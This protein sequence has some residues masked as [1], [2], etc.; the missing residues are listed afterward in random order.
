VP[1]AP[2]VVKAV[3]RPGATPPAGTEMPLMLDR[4]WQSEW[5]ATPPLQW[6]LTADDR[7][8]LE[9]F[10][11]NLHRGLATWHD[12]H[13]AAP[14][15]AKAF[16]P[17]EALRSLGD[18]GWVEVEVRADGDERVLSDIPWEVAA[19]TTGILPPAG[20]SLLQYLAGRLAVV[21]VVAAGRALDTR[22][23]FRPN[24][25]WCISNP[26]VGD[27]IDLV[28]FNTILREA[29]DTFPYVEAESLTALLGANPKWS[30]VSPALKLRKPTIFVLVAHGESGA[31]GDEPSIYF[32]DPAAT[33]GGKKIAVQQL[34]ELLAGTGCWL[35]VLICCDL[36]RGTAYS[37]AMELVRQGVPEVVAMQG[38]INHAAAKKFLDH[39]LADLLIRHSTPLA[40]AAGRL[41]VKDDPHCCLPAMFS[42]AAERTRVHPLAEIAPAYDEARTALAL[43][44]PPHAPYVSR[45]SLEEQLQRELRR[46][47]LLIV[48]SALGD[49]ATELVKECARRAA[50][51]ENR[52][53]LRPVL[54]L[55]LQPGPFREA[56]ARFVWETVVSALKKT[57]VLLPIGFPWPEE[58]TAAEFLRMI[59]S[60]RITVVIDHLPES[61]NEPRQSAFWR[62][63]IAQ[64][65]GRCQ[66]GLVCLLPHGFD[67]ET[68][69]GKPEKAAAK[70]TVP[71]FDLAAT[72]RYV[73][74]HMPGV[75]AGRLFKETGGKPLFLDA[76]RERWHQNPQPSAVTAM[77]IRRGRETA[78][79]HLSL[80]W[81][82]I[83]REAKQALFEMS[84]VQGVA[85]ADALLE[86]V[87]SPSVEERLEEL[88][89]RG[90]VRRASS[91]A[92]ALWIPSWTRDAILHRHAQEI[93]NARRRIAERF[94][95]RGQKQRTAAI[96]ALARTGGEAIIECIQQALIAT[97]SWL[98]AVGIALDSDVPEAPDAVV[99]ALYDSVIP[100]LKKHTGRVHPGLVRAAIGRA[101]NLGNDAR[102]RE[103]FAM[104]EDADTPFERARVLLEKVIWLKDTRQH[105]ALP[106]MERLVEE[107][108]DITAGPHEA[109][110][111][112][113]EDWIAL[114]RDILLDTLQVQ[115]FLKH[116][117]W[118]TVPQPYRD[119]ATELSH[120]ADKAVLLCTFAEREMKRKPEE[121]DWKRVEKWV[122]EADRLLEKS[123]DERAKTYCFY[124]YA[125]YLRDRFPERQR[126]V[127]KLFKKAEIAGRESHELRRWGLARLRRVE[128][129]LAK[130]SL[131]DDVGDLKAH[132]RALLDE[133]LAR[134]PP[135]LGDALTARTFGRLCVIRAD[136]ATDED[137]ERNYRD[138]AATAFNAPMLQSTTDDA[139]FV[140]QAI[141]LLAGTLDDPD[142]GD[143]RY[144]QQFIHRFR[145]RLE[146]LITDASLEAPEAVLSKLRQWSINKP[147]P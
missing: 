125:Q 58:A 70:F 1:D 46:S 36:V 139:A 40:A 102:V 140:R 68:L 21:R 41:A 115:L 106:E 84:F 67:L 90:I 103:L 116:E 109:D 81:P 60:A 93:S 49:G 47:G 118:A 101:R 91:P 24:A 39:F 53:R 43:T 78:A 56:P 134:M 48:T 133:I 28:G 96:D 138:R 146:K 9:E 89:E 130:P 69:G 105:E 32:Q 3:M 85:L 44:A 6:S 59:E 82:A 110:T 66:H 92:A 73:D 50:L 76:A 144:A 5:D 132:V 18:N 2:A 117:S 51:P 128:M 38:K 22:L 95:K 57:A 27:D 55:N 121:V 136:V 142:K 17:P 30:E 112:T 141:P 19:T 25:V 61:V 147:D 77:G 11:P 37:A 86:H 123:S 23:P 45:G 143:F 65:S 100:L 75:D 72:T 129:L 126:D 64:A 98:D 54:Y 12:I 114:R 145:T 80:L 74:R 137:D 52:A 29:F 127:Y 71:P 107:A 120:P 119:L 33:I 10:L 131:E 83:S 31:A 111:P 88:I 99:L 87:V 13:S 135:S 97:R 26:V 108:L 34:A 15:V 20:Q 124:Q 4:Q 7:T 62:D 16:S 14:I 63:L 42:S 122:M 94:K 79:Q 113:A 8:A 35:T 104:L